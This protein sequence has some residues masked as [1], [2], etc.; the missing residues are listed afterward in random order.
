MARATQH[1]AIIE[2]AKGILMLAHRVDAD[3]AFQLLR[4]RSQNTN[5][6]LHRLAAR[7]VHQATD[8][9]QD[10]AVA[11]IDTLFS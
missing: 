6:K 9:D 5:P 4:H 1:Q 2:Q 10:A 7:I 8:P 11:E 3:T